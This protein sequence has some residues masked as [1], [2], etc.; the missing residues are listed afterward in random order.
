[1][2]SF[3]QNQNAENNNSDKD[4][5]KKD[6][7]QKDSTKS[8]APDSK[9]A[10]ELHEER[11]DRMLKSCHRLWG[12]YNDF[13]LDCKWVELDGVEGYSV[14]IRK[15]YG[16][17]VGKQEMWTMV[18]ETEEKAWVNMEDVLNEKPVSYLM[19][20]WLYLTNMRKRPEYG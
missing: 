10:E 7:P 12:S 19:N 20:F 11:L 17:L 14:Q 8:K 3:N 18:K 2:S 13:D 4:T 6:N 1:M 16:E 9:T 5:S 15:R